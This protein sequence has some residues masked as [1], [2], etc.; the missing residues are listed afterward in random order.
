MKN[1]ITCICFV[2][3]I[4]TSSLRANPW[5]GGGGYYR[6]GYGWNGGGCYRGG[7]Y[8]CAGGWYGTGIPNG[9]GWTMFGLAAAGALFGGAAAPPVMVA[10]Q[11]VYAAPV[12]VVPAGYIPVAA[13]AAVSIVPQAAPAYAVP[14]QPV[15]YCNY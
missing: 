4:F 12:P 5:C 13:P 14:R 7:G 11:P 15:I 2:L 8:G 3:I 1:T 10:P 6:G 9:L